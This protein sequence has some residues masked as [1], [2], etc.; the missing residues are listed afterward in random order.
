MDSQ[1]QP[2]YSGR[3]LK[4]NKNSH[5][6]TKRQQ[7]HFSLPQHIRVV[8]SVSIRVQKEDVHSHPD[9]EFW[10]QLIA[11]GDLTKKFGHFG[12]FRM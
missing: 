3:Q 12:L 4:K 11:N 5:V 9:L 7:L 1:D 6:G 10:T 2:L 8:G